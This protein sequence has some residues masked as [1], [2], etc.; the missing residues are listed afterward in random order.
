[1][2][3]VHFPIS[4]VWHFMSS[5]MLVIVAFLS[6]L[7]TTNLTLKLFYP[8]MHL[9]MEIIVPLLIEDFRTSRKGSLEDLDFFWVCVN[10]R[11]AIAHI[12]LYSWRLYH[13]Y[14]LGS[15]STYTYNHCIWK[16]RIPESR[17]KVRT[18]EM[19]CQAISSL[20]RQVLVLISMC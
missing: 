13:Q 6:K 20:E 18:R 8:H 4:K 16:F 10:D 11:L 17:N 1:V 15:N 12:R 7:L 14:Y 9:H 2:T 5:Q 3:L 19:Y